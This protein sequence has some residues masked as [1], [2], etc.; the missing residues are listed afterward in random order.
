VSNQISRY[1]EEK[2]RSYDQF[3]QFHEER[4]PAA[5]ISEVPFLYFFD[6][7]K[8]LSEIQFNVFLIDPD[9][10]KEDHGTFQF[11]INNLEKSYGVNSIEQAKYVV[12][13]FNI[14]CF[15]HARKAV[16]MEV[17]KDLRVLAGDKPVIMFSI[18]DF[19]LRTSVRSTSFE[20]QIF[21][22][23]D[24]SFFPDWITPTDILI[25]FESTK[26]FVE[27]DIAVFPLIQIDPIKTH[28]QTRNILYS[29]VGTY[30]KKGWPDGFVR[31]ASS[32]LIWDRLKAMSHS[33]IMLPDE[34]LC[35][36]G[37]NPFF[38]ISKKSKFTLCPRGICCWTF[39]LFEAILCG[40]IPVILSDSYLKPFPDIIPW[41]SFSITLPES[42]LGN[43]DNYLTGINDK[44]LLEL[45]ENLNANQ[46]WF[47]SAGLLRLLRSKLIEKAKTDRSL[48]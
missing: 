27:T 39:R 46:H 11:M 47:T 26:D 28:T 29:F 6:I 8:Q 12:F 40:S 32:K 2:I 7:P 30:Y 42:E 34:L 22:D 4:E 18:G 20:K 9:L 43:V 19:C 36:D 1:L 17:L 35:D 38:E 5:E 37:N 33:V 24:L 48:A 15:N 44:T 10:Y 21:K 14:Y 13:P 25:H 45:S 41:D 3:L 23:I 16:F 31:G